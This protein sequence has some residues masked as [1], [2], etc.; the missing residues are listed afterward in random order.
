MRGRW[1]GHGKGL[2]RALSAGGGGCWIGQRQE[3]DR[4]A[5]VGGDSRSSYQPSRAAAEH[6]L[7][8]QGGQ[9]VQHAPCLASNL[10]A[11][12]PLHLPTTYRL[13]PPYHVPTMLPYCRP[14]TALSSPA[15]HEPDTPPSRIA[16]PT[17]PCRLGSGIRICTRSPLR[18]DSFTLALTLTPGLSRRDSGSSLKVRKWS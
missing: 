9:P 2:D 13:P 17:P 18:P 6:A 3:L 5:L 8:P 15:S 12:L 11:L 4:R 7:V 10:Q 1:T 16:G 14:N